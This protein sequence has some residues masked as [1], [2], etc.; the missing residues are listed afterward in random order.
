MSSC[1]VSSRSGTSWIDALQAPMEL[2]IYGLPT[3]PVRHQAQPKVRRYQVKQEY[4]PLDRIINSELLGSA[5]GITTGR[6][7]THRI[8]R[9]QAPANAGS[10]RTTNWGDCDSRDSCCASLACSI[11]VRT[12]NRR[13]IQTK[14]AAKVVTRD[15]LQSNCPSSNVTNSLSGRQKGR[16]EGGRNSR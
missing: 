8:I 3:R 16:P 4:L 10:P 6:C 15:L 2:P 13:I 1:D 12:H 11:Q 14:T 7:F 9:L 5:I